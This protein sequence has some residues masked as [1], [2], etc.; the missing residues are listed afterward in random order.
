MIEYCAQSTFRINFWQQDVQ[1]QK[2]VNNVKE[3]K[4]IKKKNF[5]TDKIFQYGHFLRSKTNLETRV[6]ANRD[7]VFFLIS[8][9][10]D[11]IT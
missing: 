2:K 7:I 5:L 10:T 4:S 9:L 1:N 3:F 8:F 6:Q 11:C